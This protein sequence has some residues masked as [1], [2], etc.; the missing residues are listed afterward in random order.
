MHGKIRA[1]QPRSSLSAGSLLALFVGSASHPLSAGYE[2]V[3]AL[4]ATE[5]RVAPATGRQ[6]AT[7]LE[8][9]RGSVH[10]RQSGLP[11]R[12]AD[13]LNNNTND[14]VAG[15]V[16]GSITISGAGYTFYGTNSLTITNGISSQNSTL[17]N[18]INFP[19]Q[20]VGPN[21]VAQTTVGG[22]LAF[23]ATV[24]LN[25]SMT[26]NAVGNIRWQFLNAG[27]GTVVKAGSGKLTM[28]ELGNSYVGTTPA[29]RA[30]WS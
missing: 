13:Q 14:Y 20:F 22:T 4:N 3:V 28:Q 9:Q 11:G 10:R 5:Q 18:N 30:R 2:D 7:W 12:Y 19:F 27:T 23:N 26:N 21:T 29:T 1:D 8:R 17:T 16:M 6:A 24:T 15:T 25:G